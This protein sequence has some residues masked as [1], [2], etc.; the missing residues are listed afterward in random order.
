MNR[1][2]HFISG[3]GGV[4]KSLV[5]AAMALKF[6]QQGRKVLL[7]ELGSRSF[8][9]S[10]FGTAPL[11]FA[12]IEL[13]PGLH[14]ALWTGAAALRE[15]ATYLVKIDA[16][17]NLI[18]ENPVTRTLINIAPALQELAILGK[19]TSGRR[20]YGP[21]LPYDVLVI[22]AYATGHFLS[23][24]RAPKGM[25]Q[26]VRFGPMGEQSRGIDACL[27]D[28]TFSHV[29]LV[30]LPEE[31]PVKETE[32]LFT[33]VRDE[34]G[35]QPQ[36]ILNKMIQLNQVPEAAMR[37]TE[38][39]ARFLQRTRERQDENRERLKILD[40]NL[41]ELPLIMEKDPWLLTE[42]MAGILP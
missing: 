8:Y 35:L 14:G 30:S 11:T 16:L 29:H 1:E 40:P 5:A 23:L 9:S 28:P 25:A 33:A 6:A 12:G 17:A 15:Y 42:K 32:E 10:F 36:V 27:R 3:K 37:G 31:L 21:P 24:L 18:F 7:V 34:F 39:F 4:G 26:A 19:V 13:R 22:D 2:A 38:P 41:V 20:H